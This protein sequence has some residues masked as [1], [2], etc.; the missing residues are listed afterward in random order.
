MSY[1]LTRRQL[2]A[3]LTA[4]GAAG[5]V[6]GVGTAALLTDRETLAAHASAGRIDLTV[7]VGGGPT[8]A[9]DGPVEL[10][11][12]TLSPGDAGATRVVL[13][14]P[15]TEGANPAYLWVRAACT[16][17]TTLVDYL[18][19]RV[20]LVGADGA[21][22]D[23][24]FDGTLGEFL[25]A[26]AVGVPLD[27]SG[28]ETAPGEQSCLAPGDDVALRVTYELSEAYAGTETVSV[29]LEAAAVQSRHG[30][31]T[32]RPAAFDAPLG[33]ADCGGVPCPCCWLVGKY[34]L[35][36]DNSLDPGV[37]PFTEG[38][39]EHSLLVSDV[40]TND[41]GE[42]MAARFRVVLT[43][44]PS[45]PVETCVVYVKSGRGPQ[46]SSDV[47]VYE[48]EAAD[49]VVGT[50]RYAISHVTLGV[51]AARVDTEEGPVCPDPLVRDP[52][53]TEPGNGN[54]NEN[55]NGNGNGNGK[56]RGGNNA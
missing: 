37:Y 4:A 17:P 48:D 39:T 40:E 54:G 42:A 7:D 6:S 46:A 33:A 35:P 12:P 30:D 9:T 13:T 8:D 45:V 18:S 49:G 14:L 52:S 36:D 3:G 26:F 28:A 47:F 32:R 15:E 29:L 10:P 43:D 31:P 38:S 34:E 22:G 50:D 24:L 56:G 44:N 5:T 41:E 16:G 55:G 11:I 21:D 25:V 20:T 2:L 1:R 53:L 27:P 23:V 19:L 51:C